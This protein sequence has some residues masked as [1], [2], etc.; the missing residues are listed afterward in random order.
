MRSLCLSGALLLWS[1]SAVWAAKDPIF[2]GS[3]LA[4]LIVTNVFFGGLIVFGVMILLS[5]IIDRRRVK[6]SPPQE[7]PPTP[8]TGATPAGKLNRSLP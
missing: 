2:T 6:K 4:G 5:V 3:A 1:Q 7:K 8:A